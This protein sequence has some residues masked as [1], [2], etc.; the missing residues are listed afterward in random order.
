MAF[1]IGLAFF[2]L[3]FGM[4]FWVLIFLAAVGLP[5]WVTLYQTQKRKEEYMET[6]GV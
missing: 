6:P 4:A 1:L 3:I 5:L 2:L